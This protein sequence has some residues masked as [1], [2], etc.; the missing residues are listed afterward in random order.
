MPEPTPAEK[1]KATIAAKA[2]KEIEDN[3]AFQ[4]TSRRKAKVD[5]K[6]NAIWKVDKPEKPDKLAGPTVRKRTSSTA[7]SSGPAKKA[8][9]ADPIHDSGPE[10]QPPAAPEA[11]VPSKSKGK[12]K[13]VERKHA[14]PDIDLDSGNESKAKPVRRINFND[15]PVGRTPKVM[16]SKAAKVFD[17]SHASEP[18]APRRKPVKMIA[19]SASEDDTLSSESNIEDSDNTSDADEDLVDVAG[20]LSEVP[21]VIAVRSKAPVDASED[22]ESHELDDIAPRKAVR[23]TSHP[24]LKKDLPQTL[25]DSDSE[26]EGIPPPPKKK[27]KQVSLKKLDSDSDSMPDAPEI[28]RRAQSD[29]EMDEAIADGLVSL[30]MEYRSRRSST[31]SSVNESMPARTASRRSSMASSGNESMPDAPQAHRRGDDS[32]IDLAEAIADSLV[33]VARS[34]RSSMASTHSSGRDLSV[35]GSEDADNAKPEVARPQQIKKK[36]KKVSALRQMQAD[37]EITPSGCSSWDISA[38]LVLPAPNKDIGLTAQHQELQYVLRTS[39]HN[40]NIDL[41]FV[42]SYRRWSPASPLDRVNILRGDFKRCAANCILAFFGLAELTPDQVKARVEELLKDHRYI[43]S[44]NS[45]TG[46]LQLNQPFRGG[47]IRFVLKEEVFSNASFVTQNLD[48]FPANDKKK[49]EERELPAAM[50]ALGATAV[51]ASLLELRLLGRRQAIAFTE[52]AYEDTYRKHME[53]IHQLQVTAPKSTHKLMHELFNDVT[54][55]H[56]VVHA[57]AGSSSTLIQLADLPDSD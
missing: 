14:A 49:P 38:Q 43:F 33:S 37:A 6:E 7:E 50:V 9:E 46:Q 39:I 31:A 36:V 51:Y 21:R 25:F 40:I 52:D 19:E 45:Q 47:A 5:A 23:K 18:V 34:R 20:F 55:N 13:A 16:A 35:P 42:E 1:Q 10:D 56:T 28:R 41:L 3:V 57:A 29:V 17:A 32:D 27:S 54:E 30:P 4:N 53:T 12:G 8:R 2:A 22:S 11:P 15:L 24:K 48:R 26:V 44:V